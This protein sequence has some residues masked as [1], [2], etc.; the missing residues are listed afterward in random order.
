MLNI[1]I[2]DIMEY[3]EIEESSITEST[4]PVTD[5]H[6]NSYDFISLIGRLES[7][8]GI[9]IPEREL[10]KLETLGDLDVYIREKMLK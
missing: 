5:L 2:N 8:L 7:E 3:V 10:R 1:I 6:L 4:N 9:T